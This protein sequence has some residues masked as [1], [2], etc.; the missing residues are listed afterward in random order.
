MWMSDALSWMAWIRIRF[1]ALTTGAA[2]SMCWTVAPGPWS[3]TSDARSSASMASAM[4]K[5]CSSRVPPRSPVSTAMRTSLPKTSG[6]VSSV[7]LM[8]APLRIASW[9]ISVAS[10]SFGPQTSARKRSRAS[11]MG[12]PEES[13]RPKARQKWT[14]LSSA[15]SWPGR[16]KLPSRRL[17]ATRAAIT[18]STPP[19]SPARTIMR[20]QR[21]KR[22]LC[23][24]RAS[25]KAAPFSMSAMSASAACSRSL[26]AVR[27]LAWPR[28]DSK[29]R[30]A[31]RSLA[32]VRQK[33]R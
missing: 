6:N 3:G 23:A 29:G 9:M 24:V 31:S 8:E 2:S 26:P 13:R 4:R 12:T 16:G 20:M 18:S 10:A 27:D 30:P 15:R 33:A 1:T 32:R 25:L 19:A 5:A 11:R 7:S 14:G 21:E 28:A 22:A 17:S